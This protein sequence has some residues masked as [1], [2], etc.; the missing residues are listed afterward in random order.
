MRMLDAGFLDNYGR[1][2]TFETRQMRLDRVWGAGF[3]EGG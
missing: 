1:R 2:L 3:C